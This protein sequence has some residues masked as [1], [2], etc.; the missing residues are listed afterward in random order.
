MSRSKKLIFRNAKRL[1]P[2]NLYEVYKTLKQAFG[3]QNW[4]PGDTPIEVAVG[5]ILTQNTAWSNVEKAIRNLKRANQLSVNALWEISFEDLA[6]LIRPAG[7]YN[8]KAKRLKSFIRYIIENYDG[9]LSEFLSR[10][11]EDL[12]RE[13]LSINGIGEE[14]ADSIILYAAKKPT[15]VI[16][17]YTRRIF[18]RHKIVVPG[19]KK[20]K[21]S[22]LL[23]QDYSKMSYAEWKEI[24]ENNLQKNEMV[25]NDFHAQIV[26]TGKIFCRASK[27]L[28]EKC[29][30]H[31]Y[32]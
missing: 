3:H 30:L 32:L 26:Y 17:A 9:E 22:T 27:V 23:K 20:V 25:F 13:L 7:Y 5:A 18:S 4:W 12:R 10:P 16:D 19:A 14:T 15:F 11:L 6:H 8:V 31:R 2:D 28:C 29:P 1:K 21:G 24:F